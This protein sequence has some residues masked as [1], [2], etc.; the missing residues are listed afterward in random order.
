MVVVCCSYMNVAGL[1]GSTDLRVRQP[2]MRNSEMSEAGERGERR[3]FPRSTAVQRYTLSD[4]LGGMRV[5]DVYLDRRGLLWIAAADGGVSRFD[6]TRF[7]TFGTADGLPHP[8][9]LAIAE[10]GDGRL[11]FG[12]LGGGLACFERGAFRVYSTEQGLPSNEVRGLQLQDDGSL[13]VLT[14]AGVGWFADGRCRRST[15]EIGGRPLGR[16]HD[17][18]TPAMGAW[19]GSTEI[20][21]LPSSRTFKGGCGPESS[22]RTGMVVSGSAATHSHRPCT[23]WTR[24]IA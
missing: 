22:C 2:W 10:D 5:E 20:G 12:T 15:T 17:M 4:G 14:G 23:T 9:V 11:W 13:R 18:A 3:A 7:E 21:S 16:V 8:T 1:P 6:G 24:T 19:D